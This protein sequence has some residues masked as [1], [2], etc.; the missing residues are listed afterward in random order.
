VANKKKDETP[1]ETPQDVFT[2]ES[3]RG[4]TPEQLGKLV[5]MLD[6]HLK[7]LHQEDSGEIRSLSDDEQKGFDAGV[8]IRDKAVS[9]I[10]EHQRVM[11]IFA[12]RPKATESLFNVVK[13]QSDDRD[14]DVRHM[15]THEIHE[16]VQRKLDGRSARKLRA[17]QKDQ[18]NDRMDAE[19]GIGARILLTENEAYRTAW[20]KAVTQPQPLYTDE[21]RDA[22]LRFQDF[23]RA[24]ADSPTSA[25]G[26]GIPVFID[27]HIIL[28][29]QG[30]GNPF[31]E[32]A[33]QV[34]V[35]TNVWKGVSSAGV[36]W[37]FQAEAAAATDNFPTLAQPSV[38]LYT[39]RGFLPYSIE[40]GM[41]YP[42]FASEMS[43]LLAAGYSEL[44][45][46][47]FTRGAGT[48]EPN[49]I[50]TQLSA[51]TNVRITV[52]TAGSLGAPDPYKVW[53]NV[54][55]RFRNQPATAWLMT[56]G[57]NNAIR[58]LG[59]S[60]V[61]HAFTVNLPENWADSLFGKRVYESPYMPDL[62]TWSTTPPGYAV[63]GDFSNYVI[64][65]NGG[66]N[67]ELIP[68]LFDVTN[69]RPTGQRGW[70]AYARIGG[71]S[72]N[73]LG[74]RLLVNS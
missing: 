8:G 50:L 23:E 14:L 35:N 71:N 72:V 37:A 45:V 27:P 12:H 10:E 25:G 52:T 33:R 57:T 17:D 39:A 66:M 19:R 62:T 60:N 34:T 67:V 15:S 59:T 48:T 3:L 6:A 63:V 29:A 26:F 1:E 5:E 16:A 2:M 55:Q 64:A 4:K 54:P 49:G 36:T 47:K 18:I 41:D 9:M 21:E 31:L 51:N 68:A 30:S 46:D 32:L 20:Q 61:Y 44:L 69:N 40:I 73:D 56:V 70:F 13:G 24:G 58:Q 22:L 53:Q 7:T 42:E 43:T 38:T 65:R 74:F 11:S 28:T